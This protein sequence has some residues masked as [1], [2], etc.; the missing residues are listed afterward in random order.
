MVYEAPANLTIPKAHNNNIYITNLPGEGAREG[1]RELG[2]LLL[3]LGF[4][5]STQHKTQKHTTLAYTQQKCKTSTTWQQ[6]KWKTLI[7]SEPFFFFF[8]F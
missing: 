6:R 8:F 5:V 7:K 3:G 1:G 4:Q 2:V